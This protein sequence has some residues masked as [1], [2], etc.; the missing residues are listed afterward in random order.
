MR[1]TPL[2]PRAKQFYGKFGRNM[3]PMS[4]EEATGA[5]MKELKSGSQ[6]GRFRPERV[7]KGPVPF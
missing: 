7:R 4:G 3:C 2:T 1:Y 6:I 5:C